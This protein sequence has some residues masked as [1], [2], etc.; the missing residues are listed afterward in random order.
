MEV[1]F[2]ERGTSARILGAQSSGE[3]RGHGL[4]ASA[5]SAGATRNNAT[6]RACSNTIDQ[7]RDDLTDQFLASKNLTPD[8]GEIDIVYANL[9][10]FDV[11]DAF[12]AECTC[13]D[14]LAETDSDDLDARV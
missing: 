4:Y 10:T 5:E 8:R 14:L 2:L 11:R 7:P 6:V 12:S 13:D 1:P 3:A 9:P